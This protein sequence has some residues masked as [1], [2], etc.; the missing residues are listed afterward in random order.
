[1]SPLKLQLWLSTS[2]GSS[3]PCLLKAANFHSGCFLK[4]CK[5]YDFCETPGGATQRQ[6]SWVE[7]LWSD[8]TVLKTCLDVKT[9][10]IKAIKINK[11][12]I[13]NF[14]FT[15]RHLPFRLI[16]ITFTVC[17]ITGTI[18]FPLFYGENQQIVTFYSKKNK[19]KTKKKSTKC[20]HPFM[21]F[22]EL[23]TS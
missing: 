2:R 15:Y 19:Q 5:G 14:N 17:Y 8:Q 22:V 21:T 16:E 1:M 4:E 9:Y 3:G 7:P 12:K 20:V 13:K 18:L 6:H 10:K 23:L 11:K